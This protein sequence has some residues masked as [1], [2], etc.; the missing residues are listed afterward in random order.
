MKALQKDFAEKFEEK[1]LE[2]LKHEE[3]KKGKRTFIITAYYSPLP[4]QK[5]YITKTYY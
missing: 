5:K 1:A 3:V 4:K 2:H